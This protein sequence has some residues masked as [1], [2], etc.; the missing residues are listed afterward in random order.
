MQP[1]CFGET[2][3]TVGGGQ[4]VLDTASFSQ[5]MHINAYPLF[6]DSSRPSHILKPLQSSGESCQH[7]LRNHFLSG[8]SA[9][10]AV[11]QQNATNPSHDLFFNIQPLFSCS[12]ANHTVVYIYIYALLPCM[13][14]H[15]Y[16]QISILTRRSARS[17][18]SRPTRQEAAQ[19]GANFTLNQDMG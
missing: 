3:A 15:D 7:H 5:N 6:S 13:H 8:S 18:C 16:S 17:L 4:I 1:R 19:G 12:N 9:A 2:S 10:Q 14:E 11:E